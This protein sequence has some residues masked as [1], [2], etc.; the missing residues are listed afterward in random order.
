M[1]ASSTGSSRG[2]IATADRG[3]TW[4]KV[5]DLDG[6]YGPVFGRDARH[7]FVLTKAGIVESTDGGTRWSQPLAPPEEL[8]GIS[9]HTWIEYDPPRDVLY[10]MKRGSHLYKLAR[11]K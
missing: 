9:A 4:K 5:S 11:N 3:K 10:I 7:L 1:T 8:D 6:Q 2:L